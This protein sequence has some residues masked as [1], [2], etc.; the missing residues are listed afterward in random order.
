MREAL[1]RQRFTVHWWLAFKASAEVVQDWQVKR[2][3]SGVTSVWNKGA[4]FREQR[5][6]VK[7][8]MTAAGVGVLRSSG[9]GY[10]TASP[11]F[12]NLLDTGQGLRRTLKGPG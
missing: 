3:P 4:V 7:F 11:A 1:H 8:L 6:E 9:K 5:I 10:L 2:L 12:K